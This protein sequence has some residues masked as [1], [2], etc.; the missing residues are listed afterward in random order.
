MPEAR[1][2]FRLRKEG[3]SREALEIA[4]KVFSEAPNDLWAIRAYGWSL[5][6]CLKIAHQ[7]NDVAELRRLY[8][9]FTGI[10]IPQDDDVLLGA[11]DSWQARIPPEG[12]GFAL[13]DVL[14]Q[15]KEASKQGNRTE[16]LKLYRE[17][18]RRFPESQQACI[19]LGWE[20]QRTLHDYVKQE[21]IDGQAIR[22]LLQEYAHLAHLKKPDNLHS[23]ILLRA[24]QAA[25]K[26]NF[27]DFIGFLRW[28][29]PDNF[30]A[31]DF[32]RFTPEG[33]DRSFDSRVEHVIRAIHKSAEAEKNKEQI[34]W[35]AEFVGKHYESFPDQEWIP[36]YY[37]QLLVQTGDLDHA[38]ALILSIVRR[39][40]TE[41]W[42]WG[43]LAA[44]F[45][46][47]QGKKRLACL[48]KALHCRT[49]DESFLVNVHQELA[50]MLVTLELFPEAKY[51]IERA[52]QIRESKKWKIPQL[53]LTMQSAPWY[54]TAAAATSNDDF[55]KHYAPLA[56]EIICEDLPSFPAVVIHQ[57]RPTVDRPGRTV[58][59][60]LHGKE[61]KE[62]TVKTKQFF[63]LKKA[64]AGQA[65]SVRIDESGPKQFVVSV[66]SRAAEPWDIIAPKIGVVRHVNEEKGVTSVALGRDAF[67]LVHHDRFPE[68][69]CI[70]PG[71][72]VAI[73]AQHDDR[74]DMLRALSFSI[75]EETP[76]S[77]FCRQFAGRLSVNNSGL[78]GF[79]DHDVYVPG[80][81]IGPNGLTDGDLIKGLAVMEFNKKRSQYGWRAV[82]VAKDG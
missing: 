69:K 39:R 60:Y 80:E 29:N 7:D 54:H 17:A 75:T 47:E 34:K 40:N 44:T 73:K 61:I 14:Q 46:P 24:A 13:A 52:V 15:A 19:S 65:F 9:E 77:S 8:Q 68:M 2:A 11:R 45:G 64:E 67:C 53:L 49:Q 42:A 56:E 43:S 55:Y 82:L 58:I 48:C 5:N 32:E 31:D 33:A 72:I 22:G 51:E 21:V 4:R 12:G 30:Q 27:S 41:F 25:E 26:G 70:P 28:W 3:K 37:G 1:D 79:A 16:A 6:D 74:R 38:R 71:T 59:G 23:L 36:Y 81:L 62:V 63:C 18:V 50:Q 20:I 35:A 76:P 57:L 78:F 10:N 66:K